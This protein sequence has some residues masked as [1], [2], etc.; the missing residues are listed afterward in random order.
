MERNAF[1]SSANEVNLRCK[2]FFLLAVGEAVSKSE[3]RQP[4][5]KIK[6]EKPCASESGIADASG[7]GCLRGL[8]ICCGR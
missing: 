3:T 6:R 8:K 4:V 5:L 1:F 7:E 2:L